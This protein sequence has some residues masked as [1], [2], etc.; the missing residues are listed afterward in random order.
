MKHPAKLLVL[1]AL[2]VILVQEKPG[3]A[4]PRLFTYVYETTTM[5]KGHWEYEQWVTWKT[6]KENDPDYDRIDFRHEFEYG[7]TDNL[8][9]ALYV[10]DWRYQAGRSVADDGVEYRSTGVEVIYNLS[11]PTVDWI[12]SALYGEVKLGPEL[13][14]LEGKILLQKNID[15]WVLAYNATI[16]AEW[17]HEDYR[18]KKGVFEQSL[19]LSYE[20]MPSLAIGAEAL[21]EL[22]FDDWSQTGDHVFYVGPNL[23]YRKSGWFVAV[24]PLFQVS[25]VAGEADFQ[26][27]LIFGFDF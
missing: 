3:R 11:H 23:S 4:D 5:P 8:Q 2:T 17:E 14:E 7:L 26:T 18:D 13:F 1:A 20:V 15:R 12:G 9:L 25:E 10:A 22:E 16:E 24:T 21:H 19:G 6:H 27:R